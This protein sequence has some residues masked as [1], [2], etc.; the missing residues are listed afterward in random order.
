MRMRRIGRYVH[1]TTR[2]WCAG[3]IVR[4]ATSAAHGFLKN[5]LAVFRAPT[6]CPGAPTVA[7]PPP[8]VKKNLPHHRPHGPRHL[9]P[10]RIRLPL[11]GC[12]GLGLLLPSAVFAADTAPRM[13]DLPGG[14]AIAT[15]K[16]F[17]AQ[18]NEQVLYSPDDVGGVQTHAVRGEFTPI[19]AL[20]RMLER[21][22][23]KAR[24]DEK[25]KA[26]AITVSK[27]LRAPPADRPKASQPQSD[28]SIPVK[29]RTPFLL[30]AGW[31]F[32]LST[33]DAQTAGERIA[34]SPFVVSS[35]KDTGYQATTTLAGTRLNTPVKDLGAS[36]SIYTKDFLTD[37]GVTNSA[38]LL[39][40]AT[41]MEAAG[42][43]G[44]FSGAT[45]DIN[46]SQVMGDGPRIDQQQSSRTRGLSA[47]NFTRGF[48]TTD[49]AFDSYNMGAVT[50]NRGPNAI[51]FGVGSPAG[52]VD[53]APLRPDLV[54]NR[55]QV[56]ARYGNND[57]RRESLD[58]NRV[59]I[60]QKLALRI[61]A[62]HDREE[63]NQRP[64][65]EEKKRIYG[66]LTF[67]PFR[68]TS[69]RGNFEAGRTTANRPITVLPFNSIPDA[70]YAA[71]RPGY[72]WTFYDDPARNPNAA[73]QSAGP[74]TEGL[75]FSTAQ[76][77]DHLAVVYA[78]P[79]A[80]APAYAFRSQTPST[81]ATAADA[82]K[83][84]IFNPVMN[85]DSAVDA[86]RWVLTNNIF[87]LPAGYW[88]GANVLPGQL[89]NLPP[90]GLKM[91][92]FTDT[93]AFD[94]AGRM[95]DETSRQGD[96]FHT[97]N[98]ALEQRAWEDRIGFE[99]AY[100]AQRFDRRS[101]NSFFSAGNANHIRIDPNVTLATGQP[102]P[103]V[104]RPYVVFGQANWT[105]TFV[106]RET[107]RATAYLKYDFKNAGG[108]W[109]RLLGR[110]TLTGLHEAN[111]VETISYSHR[112][113]SDGPAARA[114]SPV[115]NVFARRPAVIVYVGPSMIGNNDPLR[116]EPIRI[117]ELV[118]GPTAPARYF[119]RAAN[120][121]DPG[122]IAE[123]SASLVEINN[124]GRAQRE[125]IRSQA[126]VLQSYWLQEHLITL[127]GWRRDRDYFVRQP[128]NFVAN[129]A[130]PNDPG[131][132]HYG[133]RDFAF[134]H[135]PP[136]NVAK[137]I[138]TYS[139]VLRWPRRLVALPR[140]TD[141][142]VFFNNSEN[143]TPLGGRVNGFGE[144]Q[145]SPVGKTAEYGFNLSTLN[146]KLSLRMNWFKTRVQG[147][148]FTPGVYATTITNAILQTTGFWGMEG[149][150][151]P[152]LV[153]QRNAD[154][155]RVFSVLP[156]NFRALYNWQI[157]GTAPNLVA[158]TTLGGLPGTGDTSDF[159]ARGL[160]IE[161][162]CNPTRHWRILA[163]VAKQETVQTS[164]MPFLKD[165][166]SR[167]RPVW[168]E[169]KD[170]PQVNY[171]AGWQPGDPLPPS[172]V[173]YGTYL[174]T[175]V[176]VP[177]ATAV[178]TEG[179]ASAEQ[180]KWRANLVTNYTFGR[181]SIFG[182]KLKGW[183]IGG[184]VRWQDR[185]GIGYPS[186]RNPDASVTLDL[187]HPY[188]A[189]AETNVDGWVSYSRALWRE[190]LNWK[191]QLNVRNLLG[192]TA[193]IPIGVQPWGAPATV[194][195]A[196][197]RRWYLTNTFEF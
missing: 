58:L 106:E 60:R 194:R 149:N 101:K 152:H 109:S 90:A 74:A 85:R 195:I 178:A 177:F 36:I 22:P 83:N 80:R 137:D 168:N 146:D 112:L 126:A 145:P 2:R 18:A 49:I 163:N 21:T 162:V 46:A 142:A 69:I 57:S 12:M 88:T 95:I 190:R 169:L 114:I 70:W 53:S 40:F 159:T 192:D 116:L 129:P 180:R 97:F 115:V 14:D 52:V 65:F 56:V 73:S 138:M 187:K 8:A 29:P 87:Q 164:S 89:P 5:L 28:P 154:I 93:R 183:G 153:A 86:I 125:V 51:L 16:Q 35:D 122:A 105:N 10:A 108:L 45:D 121:T 161:M 143:F 42:P 158:T 39:V 94:F 13:F 68:A 175:N 174:D 197:E 148:S 155:E 77:N 81:A 134:P 59:L 165:L 66:A 139:A 102:N 160:E 44:N 54:R 117:P 166:I 43:G 189:P 64:A 23:L 96:S 136:A 147:Q 4:H 132:V 113:A 50:V 141:F 103:N 78:D 33:A 11:A 100:D 6:V 91:Q 67:E 3:A 82:V 182:G 186:T 76:L 47:P 176:L 27:P 71:G 110:H 107:A 34:M 55:N 7:D 119:A 140:G 37:L 191:V 38:D 127:V 196:P 124:G 150:I 156:G 15:L 98:V 61:A 9:L 193:M 120:A 30:L 31:L 26:I 63:F 185:L 131:K 188:Y 111:A 20:T 167:L 17:A 118:A 25:S 181:D 19:A 48:Y 24:Q 72:D 170:R 32:A 135:T 62:L 79:S 92:G 123:T 84:Q 1:D 41:G 104:G 173:T 130:D 157:S 75:L 172:V 128:I 99:L 151:N 133:F 184:A 179:S 144:S 171:P